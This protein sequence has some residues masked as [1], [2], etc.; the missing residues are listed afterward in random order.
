MF[1]EGINNS[2]IGL[3]YASLTDPCTEKNDAP[4][5]LTHR[6][7]SLLVPFSSQLHISSPFRWQVADSQLKYIFVS[8]QFLL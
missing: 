7:V 2:L 6:I 4:T 1:Y 3:Y 5:S 8:I